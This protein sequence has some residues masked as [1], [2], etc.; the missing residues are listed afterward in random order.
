[1]KSKIRRKKRITFLRLFVSSVLL[2]FM[3]SFAFAFGLREY[4]RVY[5]RNEAQ[6]EARMNISDTMSKINELNAEGENPLVHFNAYL[7]PYTHYC[8][9]FMNFSSDYYPQLASNLTE[10][11]YAVSAIIDSDNNIVASNKE[12]LETIIKLDDDEKARW[13]VCERENFNMPQLDELFECYSETG[14]YQIILDSV[15]VNKSDYSF[16]PHKGRIEILKETD[17]ELSDDSYLHEYENIGTKE[18]SIELNDEN[19]ELITLN[20][21]SSKE[22]PF[23]F[24]CGFYGIEK[25]I[26][27]DIM[28]D[29]NVNIS[30]ARWSFGCYG[31]NYNGKNLLYVD[32]MN[33]VY[34]DDKSYSLYT[35]F[36]VDDNADIV[37]K[38]YWKYVII[39]SAVLLIAALLLSWW[40]NVINKARYAFEDY[41]KVL[42]NNLAHDLKTPMTA[43]G[44]YA[45]NAKKH[46]ENGRSEH[47]I[48]FLDAITEN[49]F[50][51]DTIINRTLELNH[52][53]KIQ[54]VEK[55]FVELHSIAKT[56][57]EKYNL[58]LDEKN[59]NVELNGRFELMADRT[60]IESA[61][62]NLI[63]NAV[64]YTVKNGRI[65][66]TADKNSI[67][68]TNDTTDNIDTK[69][70][71]MPFVKDD[72]SRNENSSGIGLAIVQSVATLNN[73]KFIISSSGNQ[74][75]AVL[76]K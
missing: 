6:A 38:L 21:P 48:S 61:I 40:Q 51:V 11:C 4:I 69:D 29:V 75:K 37:M 72:K 67:T 31:K 70:L 7:S 26:L 12:K 60:T 1:M 35:V 58:I 18:I 13:Y 45:E 63:S 73:L 46:L 41:Q 20:Q 62:E 71:I 44:G 50:H 43:I 15:Y 42:I 27:D 53:N 17:N 30:N 5:I 36:I 39:V 57:I 2:A 55:E 32:S 59:I 54:E 74:F 65:L 24:V 16:I 52:L 9:D 34:I 33:P 76:S 10:N 49:V 47:I 22:A 64:K 8:I 19:Y 25:N 56:A 66:I 28:A 3:A 23:A 68:I 14:D